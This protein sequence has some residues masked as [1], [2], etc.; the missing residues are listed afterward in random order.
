[1]MYRRG[2]TGIFFLALAAA[3]L[4]FFAVLLGWEG[5][6]LVRA[7][8]EV[9]RFI[10]EHRRSVEKY[11]SNPK[12]HTFSIRPSREHSG[13]LLVEIDVDDAQTYYLIENELDGLE[14]LTYLPIFLT[15]IRSNEELSNDYSA[16]GYAMQE[17]AKGVFRLAVAS[18][19]AILAF[20]SVC[21]LLVR[22]VGRAPSFDPEPASGLA[23]T[24]QRRVRMPP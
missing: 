15:T 23:G 16:L 19:A 8:F 4:A 6:D 11:R 5:L 10:R 17:M 12:V 24:R 1:M 7:R 2:E 20:V 3:T 14:D 13:T 9:N 22:R 21:W 18:T